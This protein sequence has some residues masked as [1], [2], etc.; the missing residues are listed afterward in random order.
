MSN[1]VLPEPVPPETRIFRRASHAI[2]QQFQHRC[3]QGVIGDQAL[4]LKAVVAETPDGKVWAVHGQRR[5]DGVDARAIREPGIHHGRRLI[6]TA[7]NG[8]DDSIDDAHEV[9]IITELHVGG[10]QNPRRST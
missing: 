10:F 8:R 4:C 2:G 6:H 1:V 3:G 9:G 5:N 7:A